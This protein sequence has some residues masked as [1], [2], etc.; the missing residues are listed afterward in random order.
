MNYHFID[1]GQ[2]SYHISLILW[3]KIPS[4]SD[5][6]FK[7]F[8]RIYDRRDPTRQADMA[9][10]S[11]LFTLTVNLTVMKGGAHPSSSTFFLLKTVFSRH[12]LEQLICV[13]G[14]G[15]IVMC[16]LVDG[17]QIHALAVT[18][19]VL[20][21]MIRRTDVFTSRPHPTVATHRRR[22]RWQGATIRG[23]PILILSMGG[24]RGAA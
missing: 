11:T 18:S 9:R 13:P 16:G 19:S 15:V 14:A 24:C 3:L 17:A 12:F 4:E 22:G 5:D 7:R 2:K 10:K 20:P 6:R 1:S 21:R 23:T 8:K